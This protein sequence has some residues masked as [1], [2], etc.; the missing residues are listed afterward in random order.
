[1]DIRVADTI[2]DKKPGTRHFYFEFIEPRTHQAVSVCTG[3]SDRTEAIKQA[4]RILKGEVAPFRIASEE[5]RFYIYRRGQTGCFSLYFKDPKTGND[6]RKT[7]GKKDPWE[8][9]EVATEMY[10]EICEDIFV[11][12]PPLKKILRLYRTP[13][14]NPRYLAAKRDGTL[15]SYGHAKHMVRYAID[16]EDILM[17]R[18]PRLLNKAVK[19]IDS[20]DI[21]TIRKLLVEEMGR[22]C[23]TMKMFQMVKALFSGL[24]DEGYIDLNPANGLKD[25]RYEKVPRQAVDPNDIA[26]IL[27]LRNRMISPEYYA[28]F[29]IAATTGMR[30]GEIL[31]LSTDEISGDVLTIEKALKYTEAGC[32]S[33]GKPKYEYTRTIPLPRLTM[34]AISLLEPDKDGYLFSMSYGEVQMAMGSIIATACSVYPDRAEVWQS[35]TSHVLRHSLQSCLAVCGVPGPLSAEWL[36]WDHSKEGLTKTQRIYT[37]IY[38]RNL[39]PVAALIDRLYA[40][41]KRSRLT[42]YEIQTDRRLLSDL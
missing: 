4:E 42:V 29:C 36:G 18:Y 14:T 35:I 7:T 37:H 33:I 41:D 28:Y 19:D 20:R 16:L 8:A 17:R 32:G 5:A 40:P 26:D 1:M 27:A 39:I 10:R 34:D 21:N 11:L 24:H 30:R 25:I 13:E 38:A 23:T 9:F 22:N 2:I 6:Y 15:Y 3:R 31:A 12:S